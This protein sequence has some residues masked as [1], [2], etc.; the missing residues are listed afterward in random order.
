MAG[1]CVDRVLLT[2]QCLLPLFLAS[3]VDLCVFMNL[4]RA[5]DWWVSCFTRRVICWQC[6]FLRAPSL[7]GGHNPAIFCPEAACHWYVWCKTRGHCCDG[8]CLKL[9]SPQL[10]QLR[11]HI[12][13]LFCRLDA[14]IDEIDK[15]LTKYKAQISAARTPAAQRAAKQ[16]ALRLLKQKK[17]YENQRDQMYSQQMNLESANF[18]TEQ[19]KDTADQIT[20]M[21]VAQ[22]EIAAQMKKVNIDDVDEM[23]E[24]MQDL[25]VRTYY[26]L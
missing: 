22:G 24:Q 25:W 14:K 6:A 5:A 18:M 10:S 3:R 17:M 9:H 23:Q 11:E 7:C 4:A 16:Q 19:L 2:M 8:H 26:L 12:D 20:V 15:K 13:D 21:K 1:V